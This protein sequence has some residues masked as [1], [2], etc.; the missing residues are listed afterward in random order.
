MKLKKF[1]VFDLD[2]TLIRWQLFH[3]VINTLAKRGDLGQ[4]SYA[5]IKHARLQWKKRAH[6]NAFADYE[7]LLV[8]TYFDA[9]KSLPV[10]KFDD[11]VEHTISEYK[12]Q[13]YV[14]TSRLLKS[15]KMRGYFLL[16]I[17]GSHAELVS[18]VAKHY[19]FDDWVGSLYERKN[20]RFTGH[21]DVTYK[22]KHLTL[23]K[24]V[25]KHGL[26]YQ[27]SYGVGDTDGDITMLAAVENPIA[28]NPS[29]ELYEYAREQGWK[30]VVERKNVIYE[31]EANDGTYILA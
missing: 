6:E 11:A 5:K 8:N 10:S 28:F 14:Y 29:R 3:A 12:E 15:L 22:D 26:T 13:M 20:D 23:E 1:A 19:E 4:E 16:A 27:G 31:L 21:R 17:S 24:L 2:G 30:I 9:M 25:Q 7:M 18:H